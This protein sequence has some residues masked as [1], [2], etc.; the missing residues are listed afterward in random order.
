M[1]K[2]R[3][4]YAVSCALVAVGLVGIAEAAEPATATATK[5][6]I[7]EA[8]FV[9]GQPIKVDLVPDYII[10]YDRSGEV[11]GY[12]SKED[13]FGKKGATRRPEGA[14]TV[15]DETLKNTVGQMV[16]GVGFVPSGAEPVS[17]PAPRTAPDS[18]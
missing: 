9:P 8:A 3:I 2:K 10:A 15:V 18:R 6:R 16:P 1:N 7:P 12:V 5:G 14:I 4:S 13:L 11:A 17:V